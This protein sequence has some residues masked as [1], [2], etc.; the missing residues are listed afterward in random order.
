MDKGVQ[1]FEGGEE[2]RLKGGL[3]HVADELI[4]LE[5]VDEALTL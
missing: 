3:Q 1:I 2:L 5:L 4:V